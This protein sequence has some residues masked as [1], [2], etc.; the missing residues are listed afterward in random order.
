MFKVNVDGRIG[1]DAR[2][3]TTESGRFMTFT[4]ATNKRIK[5]N[6]YATVWLD[7]T[8]ND[9]RHFKLAEYLKKGN[10][11]CV[12]GDIMPVT[13]TTQDGKTIHRLKVT[14]DYLTF[15]TN[16]NKSQNE[17]ENGMATTTTISTHTTTT[18][19]EDNIRMNT[20]PKATTTKP[21]PVAVGVGADPGDEEQLP[22]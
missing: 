9:E 13:R 18:A 6:E 2:I 15:P 16:F 5:K 14:A 20:A 19:S 12:G 22:F 21:E 4:M 3:I 11:I 8:T 17:Q 7:V 10:A 1:Q